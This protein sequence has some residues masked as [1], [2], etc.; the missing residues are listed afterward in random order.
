[1]YTTLLSVGAHF[2]AVRLNV[3][4]NSMTQQSRTCLMRRDN[5]IVEWLIIGCLAIAGGAGW[6]FAL[7]GITISQ[8]QTVTTTQIQSMGAVTIVDGGQSRG[9]YWTSTNVRTAD[10]IIYNLEDWQLIRLNAIE[11]RDGWLLIYPMQINFAVTNS[12]SITRTNN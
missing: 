3:G 2:S 5:M 1:M 10:E 12:R 4:V 9:V 6:F 7:T 8:S 11:T